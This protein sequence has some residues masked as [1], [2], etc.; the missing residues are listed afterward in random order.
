MR[1]S[2]YTEFRNNLKACIDSV[3]SD[4]EPLVIERG[5]NN[6]VVLIPL[7]EYNSILETE[8]ILSNPAVVA[9]IEQSRKELAGGQ[10][11]EID[12]DKL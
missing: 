10:G 3:L 6:G 7:D 2:N 9:D 8:Y 12:I 11:L 4:N 5:G 1:V